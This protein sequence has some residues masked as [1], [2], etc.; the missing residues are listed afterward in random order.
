VWFEV[1]IIYFIKTILNINYGKILAEVSYFNGV[2]DSTYSVS[3]RYRN[4][5][6]RFLRMSLF[7]F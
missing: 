6:R 7:N 2:A 4:D 1:P 5:I 3:L